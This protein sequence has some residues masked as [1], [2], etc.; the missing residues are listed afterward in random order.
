MVSMMKTRAE[1]RR[2]R[3]RTNRRKPQRKEAKFWRTGDF[4]DDV[5]AHVKLTDN[6]VFFLWLTY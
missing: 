2:N 5:K 6:K 3:R 1:R 4:I